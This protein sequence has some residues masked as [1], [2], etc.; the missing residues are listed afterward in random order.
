MNALADIQIAVDCTHHVIAGSPLYPA[1]FLSV[2]KFHHPGLAP[3]TDPTGSFHI[4]Q[5]GVPAYRHRFLTAFGFYGN[6]AAV[7]TRDGWY[8]VRPDGQPSYGSRFEWVGNFL[9]GRAPVRTSEQRYFHILADGTPSYHPRY[10]YAGD[11]KDGIACVRNEHGLCLHIDLA[12]V[13]LH[14]RRYLDLDVFHKGYAR[15]RD[16]DGW[17]HIRRDGAPAHASRFAE[18]EP[19][20][21]GQA[22][23]LTWTGQRVLIDEEGKTLFR[24]PVAPCTETI[25]EGRVAIVVGTL[26]AGKTTLAKTL[27]ASR[28]GVYA[29][30]D[31][32]RRSFGDG[33]P[34]GELLAWSK[35]VAKIRSGVCSVVEFSGSGPNVPLVKVALREA[36]Q[37]YRVVWIQTPEEECAARLH[38]NANPIPYP[39]FGLGILETQQM[40][41]KNLVTEMSAETW[42]SKERV[43]ALD[44]GTPVDA[45]AAFAL[46]R[47]G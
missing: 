46:A 2:Q 16:S 39:A 27:R 25:F 19:F 36:K 14:D 29:A 44:G 21:N 9:E 31:D 38:R 7:A 5:E 45:M 30:I 47:L 34:E 43:I 32:Y 23:A 22:Y 8:H 11:Y 1:R 17:F 15:A 10:R 20:Y 37:D 42:W 40:V 12:G 28:G 18:V 26:A 35:F 6:R 33:S 24:I 4:T 3:V 41:T 13:P